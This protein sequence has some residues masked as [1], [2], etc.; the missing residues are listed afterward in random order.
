[1][2][3]CR[4]VMRVVPAV[5]LVIF[6]HGHVVGEHPAEARVDQQLARSSAGTGADAGSIAMPVRSVSSMSPIIGSG[7]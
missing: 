2:N 5:N 3:G 1:M 7:A 4:A 6:D